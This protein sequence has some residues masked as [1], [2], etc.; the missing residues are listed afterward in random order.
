MAKQKNKKRILLR[1]GIVTITFALVAVAIAVSLAITTTIN[2][3]RWDSE[4]TASLGVERKTQPERGA[5]LASDG[6][7]LACNVLVYDI[8]LDMQHPKMTSRK[9]N[10]RALDSLADFLDAHYP[11]RKNLLDCGNPDTIARYS[12]REKFRKEYAKQEKKRNRSLIIARGVADAVMD[13]MRHAP[14]LRDF[15]KS[16]SV[17]LYRTDRWVRRQPYGMMARYSIGVVNE[18]AVTDSG[19]RKPHTEVHGYSGLEKD[20]DPLLYGVPGRTRSMTFNSGIGN[21]EIVA[22]QRGFDVVTT[23]D[24]KIQDMLE[25]E[26]QQRCAAVGAQWGTAMIMEVA[27]G[28]IKAISNLERRDDGTYGEAY[29]RTVSC[30]EPGSVVKPISLLIAFEDGLIKSNSNVV[31]CSPFMKTTD[32][33]APTV[34]NIPEVMAWSSNTGVARIIFRGYAAN[35]E[36]FYDR[37]ARMKMFERMHT[38]IAE[39]RPVRLRRL[40][41]ATPSGLPI[42]MTARHL[43]LARQ[44]FGYSIE[45]SPLYLLSVY[46]AIANNGVYV[47][48]HLVRALRRPGQPDSIVVHP[49]ILPQLCTPT[50]ARMLRECLR[51]V[52]TKGTA[53]SAKLDEVVEVAGKTGTCYPVFPPGEGKGYDKSKRRFA[54]AGFFPYESPRYSCVVLVQAPAGSG[55][56]ASISGKVLSRVAEKMYAR[57]M[58]DGLPSYGAEGTRSKPLFANAEAQTLR[59]LRHS[60]GNVEAQRLPGRDPAEVSMQIVPDVRNCDIRTAVSNLEKRGLNVAVIGTGKVFAQSIPAGQKVTRGKSIILQLK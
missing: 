35:P 10:V 37:W 19:E 38:G 59:S 29:N 55:G 44:A 21:W 36:R 33:H 11:R 4:A 47:R 25:Q 24:L 46:N 13:T 50:H 48:P 27:S 28:E 7:I 31:D 6:S 40:L 56:A 30:F 22:P 45:I 53:K 54:F 58:L 34:K 60:L 15:L 5:I 18:M 52:V 20:L 32:P 14:F 12:W 1:Y 41:P 49:P 2:A 43:D 23:I 51:A 26:L 3:S 9:L 16:S 39:E 17:P 8:K 57:G 42:T